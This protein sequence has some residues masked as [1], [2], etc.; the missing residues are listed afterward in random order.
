[1][2]CSKTGPSSTEA[3]A[4][5]AWG[6]ADPRSFMADRLHRIEPRG[7]PGGIDG[8]EERDQQHRRLDRDDVE[9]MHVDR[10]RLDEVDVPGELDQL[11]SIEDRAKGE[12]GR[13]PEK[14]AD[15][16]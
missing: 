13:G 10:E 15:A 1:R 2:V 8:G 16:P 7:P 6:V 12:A 4:D 5:S 3:E 9:R 11:V 14:R